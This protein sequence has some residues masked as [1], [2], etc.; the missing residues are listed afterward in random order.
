M[1]GHTVL[2][3]RR[4]E[5]GCQNP[6]CFY[7]TE[8]DIWCLEIEHP[9]SKELD[10]QFTRIV[11]RNCHRKLEADRD[12]LKLT[13]NGLH[14]TVE[15]EDNRSLRYVMLSAKDLDSIADLLTSPAVSLPLI[16][17]ALHAAAASLRRRAR[18]VVS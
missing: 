8:T 13:K 1:D 11:C 14:K 18:L 12:V 15:S 9:V 10:S 4:K 17:D 3:K 7:C 16:A 5:L 6:R 2:E